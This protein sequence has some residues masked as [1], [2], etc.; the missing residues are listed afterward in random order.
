MR[1]CRQTSCGESRPA[2]AGANSAAR[3]HGRRPRG[4]SHRLWQRFAAWPLHVPHNYLVF[5]FD[6][7]RLVYAFADVPDQG[8]HIFRRRGS[9]VDEEIRMAI[10]D[11]RI[12]DIQ[13]LKT[14]FIDHP[15]R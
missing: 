11:T 8:E 14:E 6:V 9:R 1:S 15:A 12:A 3:P 5:E 2:S 10:A 4:T 13:A 7:E